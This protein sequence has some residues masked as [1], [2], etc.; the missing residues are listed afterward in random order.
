VRAKDKTH[1]SFLIALARQVAQALEGDGDDDVAIALASLATSLGMLL[2]DGSA[3]AGI[4]DSGDDDGIDSTDDDGDESPLGGA[5]AR[6]AELERALAAVDK[7]RRLVGHG[8][9]AADSTVVLAGKRRNAA[10]LTKGA[11]R[12]GKK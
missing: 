7:P 1:F 10:V 2:A 5:L 9:P 6:V 3:D 12:R 11:K 8:A 4:E